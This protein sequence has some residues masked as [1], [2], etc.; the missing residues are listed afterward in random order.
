MVGSRY[1]QVLSG[2]K[3]DEYVIY[4]GQKDLTNGMSVV[5]LNRKN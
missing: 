2:V 3:P 4:S 1:T 5:V